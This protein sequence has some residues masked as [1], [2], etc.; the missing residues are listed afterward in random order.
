MREAMATVRSH[1]R[2]D[3]RHLVVPAEVSNAERDQVAHDLTNQANGTTPCF[4]TFAEVVTHR[5]NAVE[6]FL[7][8]PLASSGILERLRVRPE[9][10]VLPSLAK[11]ARGE[12]DAEREMQDL[13]IEGS[14]EYRDLFAML[15]RDVVSMIVTNPEQD[16]FP[17]PRAE[18]D[19]RTEYEKLLRIMGYVGV[20]QLATTGRSDVLGLYFDN[21][22]M[23][24]REVADFDPLDVSLSD[25]L[26]HAS[27]IFG[28][29]E[30]AE[31]FERN[32]PFRDVRLT[33]LHES[34][35]ALFAR[36]EELWIVRELP[37]ELLS[38]P[39]DIADASALR[40][41][42]QGEHVGVRVSESGVFGS[43]SRVAVPE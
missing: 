1:A 37:E 31:R 9:D 12:V 38:Q 30:G 23:M 7:R 25:V 21:V 11:Q 16:R 29:A 41:G 13:G 26:V 8:H 35:G 36:A 19:D 33:R 27:A 20:Q 32:A 6:S 3:V 17:P 34:R 39:L 2:E 43:G 22:Q 14:Q 28:F 5:A 40:H 24:G 42:Q 10:L 15:S 18:T 4:A